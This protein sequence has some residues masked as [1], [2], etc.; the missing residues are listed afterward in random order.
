[1]VTNLIYFVVAVIGLDVFSR[2]RPLGMFETPWISAAG[3]ACFILLTGILGYVRVRSLTKK[4]QKVFPENSSKRMD[5]LSS[6]NTGF[7]FTLIV[8]YIGILYVCGWGYFTSEHLGL[9][10]YVLLDEIAGLVP[11]G[12]LLVISWSLAYLFRSSVSS[13]RWSFRGWMLFNM[14]ITLV[15]ALPLF[16]FIT[17]FDLLYYLPYPLCLWFGSGSSPG[18]FF[19]VLTL[20]AAAGF[21]FP[22]FLVRL[23]NCTPLEQGPKRYC[24]E[25]VCRAHN[26]S[27]RDIMVWDIGEGK[28]L[29]AGIMG[30]THHFRYVL[31]SR[32]ILDVMSDEELTAVLGHEI[33]HSKHHHILLNICISFGFLSF[34]IVAT[35]IFMQVGSAVLPYPGIFGDIGFFAMTAG[36]VVLYWRVVFGY[37]SRRFER[38]ADLYGVRV[39]GSA[40]PMISALEKLAAE[41]GRSRNQ[42]NWTHYSIGERVDFLEDLEVRPFRADAFI[43]STRSFVK[44]LVTAAAA[45]FILSACIIV[46]TAGPN[47]MIEQWFRDGRYSVL[48]QYLNDKLEEKGLE[49]FVRASCFNNLAWM[50]ATSNDIRFYKPYRALHYARQAVDMIRELARRSGTPAVFR[51]TYAAYID[52]LAASYFAAGDN[53]SAVYYSEMAVDIYPNKRSPS[54]RKLVENLIKFRRGMRTNEMP[55]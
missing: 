29:N 9:S 51:E 14:N 15:P 6:W 49:D 39:A 12:I 50:Y 36:I 16:L 3:T 53:Y 42:P 54:F 8:T 46:K 1:V 22:W 13:E 4:V 43:K 24:I 45:I 10:G 44:K 2:S 40:G 30:L 21:V 35:S 37:I 52:T 18:D 7:Q 47:P 48:E 19:V 41:G 33:G 20:L 25:S 34:F 38:Q 5:V 27:C 17:V 32:K 23:W 28:F 26:L 11:Y 55:I 31:F